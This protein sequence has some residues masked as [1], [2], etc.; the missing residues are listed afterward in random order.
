MLLSRKSWKS[1]VFRAEKGWKSVV[2]SCKNGWKSVVLWCKLMIFSMLYRK[3]GREIEEYLKRDNKRMLIVDGARQVGKT[4]IVRE[5]CGR[6]FP[7]F[8]E[9][10]MEEDKR[11]AQMF[12][13]VNTVNDFYLSLSAI[14][15]DKLK[16]KSETIVFIDEIQAYPQLFT[17]VK[18]LV[19]EGRFTYI[20]SGSMLGVTLRKTQSIPIGSIQRIHMYPLDFEEFIIAN[21]VGGMVIAS[22]RDS[23]RNRRSMSEP[24][25][26]KMMDLFRQYLLVGGMPSCVNSFV[27]EHNILLIRQMQRE[28]HELY[29]DDAS[30]YEKESRQKLK[31]QR[32]YDMIP[33]NMENKKKRV[34]ANAIEGKPGKRMA[35][36]QDEFDYLISSGIALS[37][38][39]ISQ[40]TFPLVQNMGKNLLKLYL[41]D[42]GIFSG[43]LYRN[44]VRPILEDVAS[45]NLGAVYETAVAQELMA[46]GFGLYYY[47][48]KQNGE[49]DYLIDD[50]ENMSVSPIEVKSGRDYKI[51]SAIS[52]FVANKAY[53]VKNAFVLSNDRVVEEE[54]GVLY[55]PI[56]Y[57]MFFAPD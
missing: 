39:A 8:I 16:S 18:F 54:N 45:I 32:I 28:I 46:H 56:Y 36:Y 22:M 7:Y 11:G 42:V 20:A 38:K 13:K 33:S 25:H 10:N 5:V 53:N 41:N 19:D 57:I 29:G 9:I 51:H 26:G 37:V 21:G 1:V 44:N 30:K 52:R 2:F 50:F 24:I 49:V 27:K 55:M 35:D 6:M 43:I 31:I 12:A 40:P 34:M 48:N 15:G 4:F 14:A 23:F 17:L 3:I 47:D